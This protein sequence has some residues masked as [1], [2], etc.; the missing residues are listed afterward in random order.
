MSSLKYLL[1]IV[2]VYESLRRVRI[3]TFTISSVALAVFISSLRKKLSI[4]QSTMKVKILKFFLHDISHWASLHT[5][6]YILSSLLHVLLLLE[7]EDSVFLMNVGK[8]LHWRQLPSKQVTFLSKLTINSSWSESISSIS[9]HHRLHHLLALSLHFLNLR[10]WRII[11]R[12]LAHR[13]FLI[14]FNF[15]EKFVGVDKSYYEEEQH[16]WHSSGMNNKNWSGY[17]LWLVMR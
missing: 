17:N 5:C 15:N 9:S 4:N 3:D 1:W 10:I 6:T 2:W 7:A 14:I 8:I 16:R 13:F 12:R 11:R